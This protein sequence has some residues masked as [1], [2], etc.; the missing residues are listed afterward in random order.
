MGSQLCNMK[1]VGCSVILILIIAQIIDLSTGE[2]NVITK[3]CSQWTALQPVMIGADDVRR[4]HT[5]RTTNRCIMR[6]KLKESCKE[7][8]LTCES[9]F[10]DN[11]DYPPYCREGDVFIVKSDSNIK[12]FCQRQKN[13]MKPFQPA[14]STNIMKV[15]FI[16]NKEHKLFQ[17][18]EQ[19]CRVECSIPADEV[20]P[21]EPA[22]PL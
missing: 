3:T 12:R 13:Q 6:F 7:M 20:T 17:S 16:P 19:N 22:T 21:T 9:L 8:R 18:K 1:S 4:W 10:I 5:V 14:Y 2:K 11:K 15:W